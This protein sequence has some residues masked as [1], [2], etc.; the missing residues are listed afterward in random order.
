MKKTIASLLTAAGLALNAHSA[1]TISI[2]GG[3]LFDALENPV[4]NGSLVYFIS[5]SSS[6]TFS[7]L[8]PESWV[9]GDNIQ[10]GNFITT[11]F[12]V[13]EAPGGFSVQNSFDLGGGVTTG[14]QWG[15]V[16]FPSLTDQTTTPTAG[17]AYGFYS[18]PDWLIGSDGATLSYEFETVSVGGPLPNSSG[19]A[20]LNVVPEPSTYALMALG[21][22]ALFFIAR[23][24]KLKA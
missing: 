19:V 15:M 16:W 4:A 14:D 24:R 12:D 17:M 18:Q 2:T 5:L 9:S 1:A 3:Q 10:I 13:L 8:Q 11:D 6:G 7:P 20:S 23:R 22:L 21:G